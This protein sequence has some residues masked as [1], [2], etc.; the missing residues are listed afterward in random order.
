MCSPNSELTWDNLIDLLLMVHMSPN[1]NQEP[2]DQIN[3]DVSD[4]TPSNPEEAKDNSYRI[5]VISN[6]EDPEV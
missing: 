6:I 4:I 2:A 3:Q 1:T 5:S